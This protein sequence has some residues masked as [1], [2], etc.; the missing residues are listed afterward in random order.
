MSNSVR[1]NILVSNSNKSVL[2]DLNNDVTLN[3]PSNLFFKAPNYLELINFDLTCEINIFGN[4]NNAF[5]I[6]YEYNGIEQ[7]YEIVI[8]FNKDIKSDYDL[9]QLIKTT[10]NSLS[11][12]GKPDLV[13]DVSE[14]SI[15]N[16]VTNQ[17]IELDSSTTS[18][19]IKA[20]EPVNISFNHK[21]TIG[22]L[23]GFGSAVYYDVVEIS[24]TSTQSISSYMSIDVIN[25]SGDTNDYPNYSDINCKM[26]I[27]DSNG[28]YI[29][30]IDNSNDTTISLNPHSSLNSY[31]NIGDLLRLLE[32]EM[33]RYSNSFSPAADFNVEY[34]YDTNRVKISNSTG[35]RFGIGF[36]IELTTNKVTSGSLHKVLGFEQK[37]YINILSITSPRIS[38][39]YENVFATDYVL[40]CSDISNSSLDLNIIGIGSGNNIKNNN[41]LFAIP[42]SKINN[43]SP[44]D[45]NFY[46]VSLSN[47]SFAIGYKNK[48]FNDK[49]P[50]LV[51]FYLRLLSGRSISSACNWSALFSFIF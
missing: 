29:N 51:S 44:T 14:S 28:D 38:L 50:N 49:N 31:T 13:F 12:I 22:F 39:S 4:T 40:I 10:L 7:K 35:A 19:S 21:D 18:Y 23:I 26:M 34:L 43:F 6:L 11:Y 42:L 2:Y 5:Y 47:S 33:N 27:F 24:G 8:P 45:S 3:F 25:D 37:N 17:K 32:N 41:I 20:S 16:I 30:N 46:R 1:Q 36:D 48:I 15:T 9:A